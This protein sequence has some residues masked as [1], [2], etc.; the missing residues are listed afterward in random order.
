MG[1]KLTDLSVYSECFFEGRDHTRCTHWIECDHAV[2][3]ETA[4][5]AQVACFFR[6]RVCTKA[7]YTLV[8]TEHTA[9]HGGSV[10]TLSTPIGWK[11][12]TLTPVPG[13]MGADI[14]SISRGAR[15]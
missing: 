14:G 2:H 1:H 4:D 9:L 11:V 3:T 6:L 10:I 12:N 13:F 7:P 5:L 15:L 8:H